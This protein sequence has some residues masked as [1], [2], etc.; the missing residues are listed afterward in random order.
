VDTCR[1]ARAGQEGTQV[2]S[3]HS[4]TQPACPHYPHLA[5]HAAARLMRAAAGAPSG[6]LMARDPARCG[7]SAGRLAAARWALLPLTRCELWCPAHA[8]SPAA[9]AAAAVSLCAALLAVQSVCPA[10]RPSLTQCTTLVWFM[11]IC[12]QRCMETRSAWWCI[13]HWVSHP[14]LTPPQEQCEAL[15]SA[16]TGQTHGVLGSRP[17]MLIAAPQ[18]AAH[19]GCVGCARKHLWPQE[20]GCDLVLQQLRTSK[21]DC[22]G[23][24]RGLHVMIRWCGWQACESTGLHAWA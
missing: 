3:A 21:G 8:C 15:P 23:L 24:A 7:P 16:D 19:I 22:S 5:R 2:S 18:P 11:V 9:A 6:C 12:R 17:I 14:T 13:R 1:A 20:R 10:L 4:R